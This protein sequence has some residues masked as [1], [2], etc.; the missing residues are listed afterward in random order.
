MDPW[1]V[2]SPLTGRGP[3]LLWL[4]PQAALGIEGGSSGTQYNTNHYPHSSRHFAA[5]YFAAL[6]FRF[7]AAS[8]ANCSTFCNCSALSTAV[9]LSFCSFVRAAISAFSAAI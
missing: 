7:A 8:A 2:F 1:P 5:G 6:A 9:I 4:R 3:V